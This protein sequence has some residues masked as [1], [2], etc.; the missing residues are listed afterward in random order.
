M[1]AVFAG[2]NGFG[3]D[4]PPSP[5]ANDPDFPTA[6]RVVEVLVFHADGS[7]TTRAPT[8]EDK[9]QFAWMMRRPR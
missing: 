2:S 8:A 9:A 6:E 1:L 4:H 7:E 5:P 3:M